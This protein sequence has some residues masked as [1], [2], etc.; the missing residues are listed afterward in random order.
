MGPYGNDG[1]VYINWCVNTVDS[2]DIRVPWIMCQQPNPS[3][4]MVYLFIFIFLSILYL[5]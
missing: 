5:C 4:P 2:L 1:I 3:K